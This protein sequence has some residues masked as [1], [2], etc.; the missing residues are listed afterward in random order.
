MAASTCVLPVAE[1]PHLCLPG[2]P[3]LSGPAGWASWR[4]F[5]GHLEEPGGSR[6]L[7]PPVTDLL[8]PLLLS[9][10]VGGLSDVR[11]SDSSAKAAS[12][13]P[14]PGPAVCCCSGRCLGSAW[15]PWAGGS[16]ALQCKVTAIGWLRRPGWNP[17]LGTS[18]VAQPAKWPSSTLYFTGCSA[19]SPASC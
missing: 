17:S 15:L 5:L 2:L 10:R 12:V 3:P 6:V 9:P 13:P 18:T 4:M 16:R 14:H 8:S 19:S 1:A 7:R 11:G